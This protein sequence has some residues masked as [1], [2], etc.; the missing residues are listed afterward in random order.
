MELTPKEIEEIQEV[1]HAFCLS[2]LDEMLKKYKDNLKSPTLWMSI[3]QLI[4]KISSLPR[5]YE[6]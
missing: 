5:K 6:A 2:R 4:N 3:S 1:E